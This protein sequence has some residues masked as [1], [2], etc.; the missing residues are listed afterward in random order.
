M[1]IVLGALAALVMLGSGWV[2]YRLA[3]KKRHEGPPQI[4][5]LKVAQ[6]RF[7]HVWTIVGVLVLVSFAFY[8]LM[9]PVSAI[10]TQADAS[11]NTF[12]KVATTLGH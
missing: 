9:I 10:K 2:V 12:Q 3:E 11:R 7:Y 8:L 5:A 6:M 1:A 4:D